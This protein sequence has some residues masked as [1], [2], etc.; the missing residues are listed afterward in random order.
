MQKEQLAFR[1]F[2][3]SKFINSCEPP[4]T[5]KQQIL[6]LDR[7]DWKVF[8]LLCCRLIAREHDIEGEPY[9]YGIPGEDQKGI[10]IV[11]KKSASGH[12]ETWCYQCKDYQHFSPSEFKNAID[13]LEYDADHYIFLLACKATTK[14]RDIAEENDLALWDVQNISSKLKGHPDLVADFFGIPWMEA[15]CV[16]EEGY[17]QHFKTPVQQTSSKAYKKVMVSSAI[18]YLPEYRND[19]LEACI[20]LGMLPLVVDHFPANAAEAIPAS[21]RAVDEA[22]IYLGVF[23]YRY[24]YIPQNQTISIAEMEYN[25]AVERNIPRIIWLMHEK[26][27]ITISDVELGEGAIKLQQ[28][29][30]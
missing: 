11:A 9:L 10:D 7:L 2:V 29:K 15:F 5:P 30:K 28:F 20:R 22:D 12:L 4:V 16:L 1:Y 23:A 14:L 17:T 13:E 24:G 25:H 26:H 21:L 18:Q 19:A 27:P 3:E 8:E 6:P